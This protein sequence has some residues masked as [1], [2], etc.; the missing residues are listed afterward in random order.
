MINW[1]TFVNNLAKDLQKGFSSYEELSISI[2]NSYVETIEQGEDIFGKNK[3]T[4]FNSSLLQ[5]G[6]SAMFKNSVENNTELSYA[7]FLEAPLLTAWS[8]CTLAPSRIPPGFSAVYLIKIISPGLPL[9][10]IKSPLPTDSYV[11]FPRSLADYFSSQLPTVQGNYV[12]MSATIPPAPLTVPF[13][14][15][16]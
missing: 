3:V 16:N 10:G 7:Q 15:Y 12:G 14:G 5:K 2:A 1:E 13:M 6:L 8:T 11:K 4:I 9:R